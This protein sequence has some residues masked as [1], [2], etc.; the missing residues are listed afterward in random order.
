VSYT[1]KKLA[2]AAVGT[3]SLAD[4]YE[5]AAT[6]VIHNIII[7]NTTSGDL[8]VT[9]ALYYGSAVQF[10][11]QSI[12]GYDMLL[13]ALQNEGIVLEDNDKLQGV[14]AGSGVNIFVYG[15]N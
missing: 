14:A 2:A 1:P 6:T 13:I 3:G 10:F 5:A 12:P 7:H 4:V 15:S 8:L 9:L 11:R